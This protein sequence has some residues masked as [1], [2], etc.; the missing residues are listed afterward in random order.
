MNGN[1]IF[2]DKIDYLIWKALN[3]EY[4]RNEHPEWDEKRVSKCMTASENILEDM[5]MLEK[6]FEKIA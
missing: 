3:K 5:G 1:L 4:I 6:T 2:N